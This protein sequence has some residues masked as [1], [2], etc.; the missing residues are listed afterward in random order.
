MPF[1]DSPRVI[2]KK[3]PLDQVICQFR[4]PPILKID[5]QSPVD[6][7]EQIRKEYP[8]F[9]EERDEFH[10][11]PPE[12]LSQLPQENIS[13]I[14]LLPTNKMNY[15]FVS[16][17][18]N[19]TIN[20]T[21]SFLALSCK[22]YDRWENFKS[23]FVQPLSSLVDIY[24]PD[25]FT[26]IGLRYIDLIT[27]SSLGLEGYGWDELIQP[28]ILGILASTD[29]DISIVKSALSTDEV[30]IERD[31]IARLVHGLAIINQSKEEVYLI[32]CDYFTEK[33]TEIS[34]ATTKLDNYNQT[35][36]RLF[37]WCITDKLHNAMQPEY[38]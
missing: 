11:F 38:L 21:N 3:N 26:R 30:S 4:F 16:A 27:R 37:R 29:I 31:S 20:L 15:R 22:N 23:H 19:W 13:E 14:K 5:T 17:D 10:G 7:Q 32:D 12:V 33:R 18:N 25:F 8:F 36:R 34:D 2:Y 1:P 24:S 9:F 35:G 28:N 6:F